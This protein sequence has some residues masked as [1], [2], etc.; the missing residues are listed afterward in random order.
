[1]FWPCFG[2]L[3]DR[4]PGRQRLFQQA[5]K[6]LQHHLALTCT[7]TSISGAVRPVLGIFVTLSLLNTRR[8]QCFCRSLR[9]SD[10]VGERFWYRWH[11]TSWKYG[12]LGRL[13]PTP[14]IAPVHYPRRSDRGNAALLSPGPI[15]TADPSY[16]CCG[17]AYKRSRRANTGPAGE[18]HEPP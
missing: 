16:T 18:I 7:A 14:C 8:K 1:M 5:D 4:R 9:I 15:P 10:A 13:D 6:S 2:P 11:R 17:G 12:I 3:L